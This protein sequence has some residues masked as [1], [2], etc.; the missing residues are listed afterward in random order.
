MCQNVDAEG[1]SERHQEVPGDVGPLEDACSCDV[2]AEEISPC[3][4]VL[5][6]H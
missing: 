6:W 5:I 2:T 3:S 1:S 4:V